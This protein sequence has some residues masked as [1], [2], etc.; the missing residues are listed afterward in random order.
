MLNI[1]SPT[2]L[3]KA[4]K[5]LSANDPVMARL[6]K[7]FGPPDIKPHTNYYQE[8][9]DSIIGQQLSV[10]A[11]ATIRGRFYALFGGNKLPKPEQIISKSVEELRTA[12]LSNAKASYVQDLA[13]HIL[14]G[15]IKFDKIDSLSNDE[16]AAEL[17]AVKG[18][19][20]WTAH[21]F[22]MFAMG[23]LDI[24]PVGD[25]GI[26]NGMIK[27]YNLRTPPTAE[28]IRDIATKNSW[29]PYESVASWYVWQSLDN[30]PK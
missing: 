28:E 20:E 24:L 10:K 2:S 21:M 26:K 9:V 5:H 27:L 19:G 13:H 1:A 17:I 25:L 23:R 11:A 8:L 7:T 12:G 4:A 6:V 22:M 30:L 3:K 29:H 18:V 16:V 15:K 14:E